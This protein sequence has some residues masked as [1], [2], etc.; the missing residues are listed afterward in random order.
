MIRRIL[1]AA[2]LGLGLAS[3]APMHELG[4]QHE[5]QAQA[6]S[7][8]CQGVYARYRNQRGPKAFAVASNGGCGSYWGANNMQ[9]ARNN[10]MRICNRNGRGCRVVES[11]F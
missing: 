3:F 2:A 10:A 6:P 9:T 1:V 4:F 5:A 7:R 11:S 8:A